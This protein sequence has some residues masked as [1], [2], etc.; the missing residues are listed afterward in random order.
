MLR[1]YISIPAAYVSLI[2]PLPGTSGGPGFSRKPS[3]LEGLVCSKDKRSPGGV[4][5]ARE[6]AS[7][8]WTFLSCPQNLHSQKTDASQTLHPGVSQAKS[9]TG[10]SGFISSLGA[11]KVSNKIKGCMRKHSTAH[12]EIIVTL[13]FLKLFYFHHLC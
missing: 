10:L 7:L 6:E 9:L 1:K 11:D 4:K 13:A 5:A 2:E 3:A 12:K 8:P